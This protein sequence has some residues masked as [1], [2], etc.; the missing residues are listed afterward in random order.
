[1]NQLLWYYADLEKQKCLLEMN[2]EGGTDNDSDFIAHLGGRRSNKVSRDLYN[3]QWSVQG[4]WWGNSVSR[5][6]GKLSF[7]ID[8]NKCNAKSKSHLL[9]NKDNYFPRFLDFCVRLFSIAFILLFLFQAVY[10][11]DDQIVIEINHCL[12]YRKFAKFVFTLREVFTT[13]K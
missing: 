13:R 12:A 10:E 1:M 8:V 4:M 9:S 3:I 11:R 5:V 7:C 6:N 2:E